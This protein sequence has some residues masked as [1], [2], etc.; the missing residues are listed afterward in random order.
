MNTF[1][2]LSLLLTCWLF[3]ATAWTADAPHPD[4]LVPHPAHFFILSASGKKYPS[5][6]AAL[7]VVG[8]VVQ[9]GDYAA[10]RAACATDDPALVVPQGE[11]ELLT[12]AQQ[13]A[14]L[15][16]LQAGRFLLLD[17]AS[18]LSARLGAGGTAQTAPAQYLSLVPPPDAGDYLARADRLPAIDHAG[19]G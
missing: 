11:C 19:G 5:L 7:A 4:L 2:F 15:A 13:D 10:Y 3:M 1:R 9:E 8:F 17:G 14:V 16:D 6:H 12:G 18:V